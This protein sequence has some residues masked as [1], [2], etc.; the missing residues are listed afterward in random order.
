MLTWKWLWACFI[1]V[2]SFTEKKIELSWVS[3][4]KDSYREAPPALVCYTS[5]VKE[6]ME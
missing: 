5:W 2:F 1:N 6:G 4:F 3:L